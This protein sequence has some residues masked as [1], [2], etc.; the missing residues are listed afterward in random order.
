MNMNT[1]IYAGVGL[2]LVVFTA[3][4]QYQKLE[5]ANLN[6]LVAKLKASNS[7]SKALLAKQN[8]AIDKIA[9]DKELALSKLEEWRALPPQIKYKT[10][11]KDREI[12][13]SNDSN[14]IEFSSRLSNNTFPFSPCI[15]SSSF[16]FHQEGSIFPD[17][18]NCLKNFLHSSSLFSLCI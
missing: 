12:I 7:Q 15:V 13:K 2:L 8:E 11:Y 14:G 3:L 4:Y 6:L 1:I 10:I 17:F 18:S 9:I 5:I 16:G